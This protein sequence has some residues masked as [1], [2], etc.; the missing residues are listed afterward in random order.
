MNID[1]SRVNLSEKDI[2]DWL[3]ENPGEIPLTRDNYAPIIHWIGRQYSLPSGI[4]D[5]IGVRQSGLLVVI[6][7][8]NVPINKA[9]ILQVCRYASDLIS[10]ASEIPGYWCKDEVGTANVQK[11][12]IGPS[13]D[14]QTLCEA[15]AV[16]VKVITFAARLELDFW[17]HGMGKEEWNSWSDQMLAISRQDEWKIFGGRDKKASDKEAL[18]TA[19]PTTGDEYDELMDAIVGEKD[20][21]PSGRDGDI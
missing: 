13:I 10:I 5:L 20:Q 1:I 6:E 3:Y 15:M 14:R 17:T 9:A 16:E 4:A 18:E 2:E 12:V 11:V 21:E 7:V 8:K 19:E